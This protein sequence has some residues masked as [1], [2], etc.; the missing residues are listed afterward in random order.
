MRAL[1]DISQLDLLDDEDVGDLLDIGL[2]S[3]LG[4]TMLGWLMADGL[5]PMPSLSVV[6]DSPSL[7]SVA[8][9]HGMVSSLAQMAEHF[10]DVPGLIIAWK[11]RGSSAPNDDDLAWLRAAPSACAARG[12][13]LLGVWLVAGDALPLRLDAA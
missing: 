12:V 4:P 13:R 6:D 2:P 11:R 3:L 5:A 8:E 9:A 1:R 7:V 10:S